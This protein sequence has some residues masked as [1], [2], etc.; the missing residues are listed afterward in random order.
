MVTPVS[1]RRIVVFMVSSAV[2]FAQAPTRPQF[3]VASIKENTTCHGMKAKDP[4]PH[5]GAL[6]IPCTTLKDLVQLSYV[7]FAN[8]GIRNP[9][10][11]DI[12]GGPAWMDSE[13]FDIAAKADG[14]LV[15][16]MVG[17]MLQSL[18]EDRFKVQVHRDKKDAPVYLLTVTKASRKL[19]PTKDGSCI[20][21]DLSHPPA[22]PAPGEPRPR[23]CGSRN[24]QGKGGGVMLMSAY[25]MTMAELAGERLPEF[26][27][28]PVLD[29]TGLTGMFDFEIEFAVEL[30]MGGRG[31]GDATPERAAET[32]GDPIFT[33]LQQQLGLKLESSKAPIPVLVIDRAE[34]PTAN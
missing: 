14:A 31:G 16:Q 29:R 6:T 17:P 23:F 1:A 11:V 2:S 26:V 18:L 25:G 8:G 3:D 4:I 5:P 28:R 7:M 22:P 34:K 20:V 30:R 13:Y 15:D 12:I 9:E 10:K 32:S 21:V 27:G 19:S 24:M 33:A